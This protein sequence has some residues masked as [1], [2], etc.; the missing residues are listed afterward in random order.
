VTAAPGTVAACEPA[1][2]VWEGYPPYD[3]QGLLFHPGA[4][5]TRPQRWLE[6]IAGPWYKY[7]DG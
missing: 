4:P 1:V 5:A 7:S 6:H 3:A 2:W